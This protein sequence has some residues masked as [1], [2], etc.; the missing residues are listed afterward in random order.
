MNMLATSRRLR[1]APDTAVLCATII[2][3]P[4]LFGGAFA[5]S[6]VAIAGLALTCLTVALR[7]R[8][9]E[10]TRILDGVFVAMAVAWLW[11]CV[12][13][14]PL[15]P[16]VAQG[17]DLGSAQNAARLEGLAWAGAVPYTV[18]YDPG[19]T[20]LQIL[21]GVCVLGS[22]L[23][24]RLGGARGLRPLAVTTV[25]SAVL[26]GV[27]G[28]V[29]EAGGMD[30]L[31]GV[32]SVRF[33]A[34]HLLTPLMNSNHLGGFCLMGALIA[35][36]LAAAE[37]EPRKRIPWIAAAVFCAVIVI[38]TVSRGAI[39]SLLFGFLLLGAWLV[40]RSDTGKRGAMIPAAVVGAAVVAGASFAGL[41][42]ILRRFETDGFDKL[43][44][45]AEGFALLKGPTLWLG[46]GRG[47]FSS[48]FVAY[49]GSFERYTHPE[50]IIVQWMTEWGAPVAIFLG[51][52]VATALWKRFRAVDDV[53]SAAAC[54]AIFAL[55]LQNLVDFSLEMAGIVVVVSALLGALLPVHEDRSP[56]RARWLPLGLLA[57]L[58][59]AFGVLAPRAPGSD[60]Q[61]IVDRLTMAMQAD[62][63]PKFVATL[64][65][66]L[67]L[68]PGE[69][70]FSL[71]A[72]AYAGR[73]RHPDA[74]RWMSIV[75]E[76]AP[77]WATPH[78]L[79]A[80][81]LLSEGRIDQALLEIR[82]A[83]VRHP[84][85][86]HDVLCAL[87][88]RSPNIAHVLRAAPTDGDR[89]VFL[90]RTA[91]F[92]RKLPD[93]LRAEIDAVTLQEDPNQTVAALRES[94]RLLAQD[95]TDDAIALLDGALR[96]NPDDATLWVGLIRA[97]LSHGDAERAGEVLESASEQGIDDGA[98]NEA[99]AR[100]E[101]ALG[102]TERMRATVTRLRGRARGEAAGIA[103]SFLLEAELEASL[104]NVDEALAAYEAADAASPS[105][106]TLQY[107]ANLAMSSGRFARA[108]AFYRTMCVRYPQSR[109]CAE[110]D[111]LS[112]EL[113]EQPS[114]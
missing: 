43:A 10:S 5:W 37:V 106:R 64:Q 62:D 102:Q 23:A 9:S 76:E 63:E 32:Y 22:F 111:R 96:A 50:N 90:N 30:A 97:H 67:S 86:G 36:G 38:W 89:V 81:W 35:A 46:V 59:A 6:V 74:A 73:K 4:Q 77:G 72:A 28:L 27:V 91:S 33:S 68:H 70:A 110:E 114:D 2:I 98:L 60:T 45:A 17:L 41:E 87:L 78:A 19:S 26:I 34:S 54:I 88:E 47:A 16:R 15:A 75:M 105:S 40:S 103:K 80:R 13:I 1:I 93:G 99:Q 48:A 51:A 83:E 55:V 84:G 79:T 57:M 8:R 3:A 44:V 52:A 49:E 61:S 95:Q 42:P 104:G 101:A 82:E 18:S 69:P 71:L 113:G 14:A 12:Q 53:L 20:R 109:G 100:V 29:H 11:T 31:F 92:C 85:S 108:R 39:G 25:V 94:R 65:R 112:R 7:V 21:I 56:R 107:A 58:V 66:G 24:A